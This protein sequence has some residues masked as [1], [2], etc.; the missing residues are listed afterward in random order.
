MFFRAFVVPEARRSSFAERRVRD[1]LRSWSDHG[2]NRPHSKFWLEGAPVSSFGAWCFCV[3]Q[4]PVA[5]RLIVL[6]RRCSCVIVGR[7]LF[8]CFAGAGC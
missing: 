1:G 6:A 3:L 8:L 2:R 4:V 7:V 5:N